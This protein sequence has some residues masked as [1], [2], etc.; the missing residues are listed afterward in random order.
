MMGMVSMKIEREGYEAPSDNAY[1][2][3]L[4]INLTE[5]QVEALGL[6]TSPP[7]AGAKVGIRAI[8]QVVTVTQDAD[9]DGD[10]DGIDVTLRLQITDMEVNASATGTNAQ[11]ASLL[12]SG[13]ND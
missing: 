7:A 5:D 13:G 4:C 10:G 2:Y 3:G 9:V 12:Y 1:G 6:K 11:A 8:A